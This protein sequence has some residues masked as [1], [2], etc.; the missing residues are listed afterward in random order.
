[1]NEFVPSSDGDDSARGDGKWNPRGGLIAFSTA[2]VFLTRIPISLPSAPTSTDWNRSLHFF[3]LVGAL[4]GVWTVLLLAGGSL[5]WPV[6]VAI[7]IALLGEIAIT[8]GLHEDGLADCCDAFG[9]GGDREAILRI[10]KDS[11][12]GTYGLLGLLGGVGI[13]Y[14]ALSWLVTEVGVAEVRL[15]GTPIVAATAWGRWTMVAAMQRSAPLEN[16]VSLAQHFPSRFRRGA[17]SPGVI[18]TLLILLPFAV[19]APLSLIVSLAF[20]LGGTWFLQRYF[21]GKLG[22]TT[23]DCLG[24]LGYVSQVLFLLGA[25]ARLR[26]EQW[27]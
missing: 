12:L 1:M 25:I 26:W 6:T 11:R 7:A 9:H 18:V 16:R 15:W 3:P 5:I 13:K 10:L 17:L 14:L 19:I 8:G 23:G 21:L 22:G 20:S 27:T 2:I 24:C 4:V